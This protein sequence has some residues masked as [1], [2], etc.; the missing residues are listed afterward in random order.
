MS[1][2]I[3]N[4]G[5][6]VVF[7]HLHQLYRR[8]VRLCIEGLVHGCIETLCRGNSRSEVVPCRVSGRRTFV[9]VVIRGSNRVLAVVKWVRSFVSG[10]IDVFV[11]MECTR[12]LV[13]GVIDVLGIVEIVCS[14]GMWFFGF[15]MS[16]NSFCISPS[17]PLSSSAPWTKAGA[18][19]TK[20]GT[21]RSASSS[22]MG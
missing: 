4:D 21:T 13:C 6:Q 9:D 8:V 1:A 18:C 14:C 12:S 3:Q 2:C 17:F 10:V 22:S 11:V 5:P 16:S 7:V 15:L 19:E 20:S